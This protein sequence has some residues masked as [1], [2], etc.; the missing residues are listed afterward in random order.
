MEL[1]LLDRKILAQL[2]F[3]SRRS[4]RE[5]AAA[6][7]SNKDTV[8]YRIHRLVSRG[9]IS[10]FTTHVDTARLGFANI[11]TYV[12][13]QDMDKAREREFFSFLESL[14]EVGWVV[15]A[16]GRW[17]ALFCT[18]A[19][20]SF[21]YYS[22]LKKIMD[23]FS[24]NIFEKQ[25]IHN[26]N[27]FYYNRKWLLPE[28]GPVSAIKYGEEPGQ[29][30]VDATD[31]KL[32]KALMRDSRAGFPALGRAAGVPPQVAMNRVRSLRKRGIITKY[33][34]DLDYGKLGLVFCKAFIA[35][36][37][38][39]DESLDAIYRFCAREPRIFALTTTV[40][41]WDLEL[42]ME[43]GRVEQMMDIMDRLKHEF[44]NFIRGYDSIVITRQSQ[45]NY[46]PP[47]PGHADL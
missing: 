6:A 9:I 39:N 19:S 33:G 32:L 43:V 30:R 20:S 36:Y 23:R 40:G 4:S 47:A 17:D 29:E 41:A 38:I 25:V 31:R 7:G 12:R 3:D 44:P 5:I 45:I 2:D 27:W 15:H 37:N 22:A 26:I 16:S 1:D 13:F 11:K 34:V 28:G 18:W 10:G 21:S 8:N 42:E 46:V 24:R 14:P 35:L